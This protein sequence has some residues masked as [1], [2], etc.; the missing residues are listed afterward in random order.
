MEIEYAKKQTKTVPFSSLPP[1]Q[2]FKT[3]GLVE[4]IYMAEHNAFSKGS[5][6]VYAT[7]LSTGR[8]RSFQADTPVFP[9]K[10]KVV[11]E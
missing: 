11:I 8:Y 9:V 6:C 2:V 10:A 3:S 1:G 4:G 7:N 5:V